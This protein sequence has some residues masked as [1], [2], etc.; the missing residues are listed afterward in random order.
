MPSDPHI[1]TGLATYEYT[2]KGLKSGKANLKIDIINSNGSKHSSTTYY[3]DIDSSLNVKF[4]KEV[5]E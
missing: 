2:V 4:E 1:K 3:F 5:E